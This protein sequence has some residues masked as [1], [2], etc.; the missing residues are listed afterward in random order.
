MKTAKKYFMWAI[1]ALPLIGATTKAI[2]VPYTEK[3]F[4]ELM[5][6]S[7]EFG[8]RFLIISLMITPLSMIFS[9]TKFAK[10]LLRNR[11]YFGV[12]AFSYMVFHTVIYIIYKSTPELINELTVLRY[13]VGWLAL[14][15][16]IPPA[17]TSMNIAIK[18]LGSK[19]WKAI[20]R[21]A[22][23]V[24]IFS[25]LH[26]FLLEGGVKPAMVHFTPL[27]ILE[28]YRVIKV[29][30]KTTKLSTT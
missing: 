20:Q 15:L 8:I 25:A 19:K 5:H 6:I 29:N 14:F 2:H 7:G 16:V 12:A 11:R 30:M 3:E 4:D 23:G 10:W 28:L 22:Y 26:W 27:I 17:I 21:L 1:L 9:R 24:G 18:K 13:S